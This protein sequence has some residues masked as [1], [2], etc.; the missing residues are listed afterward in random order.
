MNTCLEILIEDHLALAEAADDLGRE[1]I[2]GGA[3][4]AAGHDQGHSRVTHEAQRGQKVIGAVAD[5]EDH[6]GVDSDLCQALR[7]PGPVGVRND[8]GEHFGAGDEDA[9]PQRRGGGGRARR[10]G[11][12]AQRGCW[13]AESRRAEPGT[14]S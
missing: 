5:D 9:G 2:R 7:Q 12:H 3:E 11:G 10:G 13:A 8:P 4:A 6:R 14:S 1:V